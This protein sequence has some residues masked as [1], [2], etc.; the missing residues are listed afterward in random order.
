LAEYWLIIVL[1]PAFDARAIKL[2]SSVNFEALEGTFPHFD[3]E[4]PVGSCVAVGH[5][6]SAYVRNKDQGG[7]KRETD[8]NL[9][10]NILFVMVFGTP[11]A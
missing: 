3:G 2:N 7:V 10:S 1:V 11:D 5:S 4:V 9:G 8:A 6:I